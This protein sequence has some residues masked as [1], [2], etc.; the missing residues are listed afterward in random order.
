MF[1]QEFLFKIFQDLVHTLMIDSSK[2]NFHRFTHI[3]LS[4]VWLFYWNSKREH[5]NKRSYSEED[6]W[7][8][9]DL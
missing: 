4:Y 7:R 3:E 5:K 9:N 8:A 6:Y 1:E 2:L